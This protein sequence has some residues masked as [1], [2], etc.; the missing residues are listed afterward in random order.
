MSSEKHLGVLSKI[1]LRAIN[2]TYG[3][4]KVLD[5][6]SLTLS[7]GLIYSISGASGAGKTTLVDIIVGLRE[8]TTGEVFVD[9]L[10]LKDIDIGDWRSRIGYLPQDPLLFNDSIRENV[11]IGRTEHSEQ[12]IRA[13]CGLANALEFIDRLPGGLSYVVGERGVGLSGGQ[14]QRICLARALLGEPQ[15]LVLDEA[16]SALDPESEKTVCGAIAALTP[17]VT[18]FA[19]SH[20][21]ALDEIADVRL[22]V[23]D[24]KVFVR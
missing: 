22:E 19:I 5:R 20:R 12:Q 4:V 8:P 21:L 11:C 13:A 1:E 23:R 14:R 3:E 18:V 6:V 2:L 9:G 7:A 16:T 15:I 17:N 24:A 10:R